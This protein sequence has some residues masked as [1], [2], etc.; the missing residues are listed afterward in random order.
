MASI[1]LLNPKAEFAR[2][3]QAL[4]IN[5]SAAKGLQDVMRT[6]LGPKG[7]M[8]MLVSGA[9][10]IKITKDGNVLL[11]EMQIQ[12]PTASMI[13]R[14][15][16][17]Q[18]DSTGDGTTSTVL[19]IGELLKQAD[20]FLAEGLHPRIVTEGF[21]KAREQALAVLETMKVPIAADKKSLSEVAN[22][23]LKTK[24]HAALADLLTDV[25]VDAVLAI[26]K[27]DKPAD[28]HMIEIM[29]MQHK[30]STDTSLIKGLVMDHGARHPDM[31]KRLENAY[32]LTCNVS[33]EYE[34]SEVNSGFFYK[35]A[36]EREKFVKAERDF[37]DQRVKKII[38]LKRKVC[39]GT[40][41]SFVVINQK[42]IDPMSLDAL[43]KEGIM[44]LR[45]AKRRNMERL[46]LA[47]GGTAMNSFDDLEESHLGYA[48]LVYEHT[49]GENK[50]TFVEECK[51]PQSVTILIKGPNKH[52]IVQIKDAI[53][54]GLR[55]IN[56][57]IND[58]AVIP[59]AA[60][61]E[62]RA[63]NQLMKY[64]DTVKGKVRLGIQAFAE[65]LLVIPKNLA[66]NSGYDA[67]DTIVKLT[68]EDRLN[69]DP[70]G[71]DLS[72]GEAMKP[73]DLGVYD[74]YNVKKQIL[75]SCS[76]IASN[77]LLVDE[78]MRAGMTSLKG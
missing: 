17:A 55:A 77:L 74:N 76:V 13:A 63:F 46:A 48:G 54:D 73:A 29:E 69:P 40:E 8:K 4:A 1:S 47:C 28:L 37:I 2:A 14:A 44:A 19:L 25:C 60:A 16:T 12:H 9:G 75:N 67:Q 15:S 34:K 57:A 3:A 35:T 32:I 52:T 68:E 26:R 62:V 18:D 36:E 64:K 61:F 71:L 6:N 21:E 49:L 31:P 30:T 53:R 78:V 22:T 11:H 39:D 58:K 10:D 72:T 41:K 23:S 20:I 5:I 45:R 7:T 70:V 50:Y 66:I 27:D 42:G 56:N 38:E 65:A 24:V 59:G 51:N 43:A 33:L